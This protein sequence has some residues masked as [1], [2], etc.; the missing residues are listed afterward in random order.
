MQKLDHIDRGRPFDWGKTSEDYAK[1]RPG[2][3]PSFFEFLK[4]A[5]IGLPGQRILDLA[6][7]TGALAIPFAQQG[8]KVSAIDLSENQ[9]AAARKTARAKDLDIDFR[10]TAA[11]DLNFPADSF[12]AATASMCWLYLDHPKVVPLI[13]RFLRPGGLL[14]IASII[15]MPF[16][17]PVAKATED[18]VVKYN[19]VWGGRGYTDEVSPLPDWDT[20]GMRVKTF[21]RYKTD[22]P[23]TAES[24]RGRIR[25]CRGVGASLPED[26]VKAFDGELADTLSRIAPES[27]TIRHLITIRIFDTK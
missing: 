4:L 5:G 18:L 27:F 2:Y 22:V 21:H 16:D 26:R 6:T 9:V 19:P 15:W 25:A 24:W 12:D 8:A 13:L 3:P 23:F 11:E 14:L 20:M 10:V 1:Y 17:D 7:G